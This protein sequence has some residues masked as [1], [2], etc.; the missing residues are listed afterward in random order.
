M[1]DLILKTSFFIAF[2]DLLFVETVLENELSQTGA[3]VIC[4]GD[5]DSIF[6]RFFFFDHKYSRFH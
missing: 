3:Y 5:D 4:L 1:A 2:D 6:L